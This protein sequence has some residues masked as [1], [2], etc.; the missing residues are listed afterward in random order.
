M[1]GAVSYTALASGAWNRWRNLPVPCVENWLRELL[2]R[3]D[4]TSVEF[5]NQLLPKASAASYSY[6]LWQLDLSK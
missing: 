2:I 5:K 6:L 1:R 4:A 3:R